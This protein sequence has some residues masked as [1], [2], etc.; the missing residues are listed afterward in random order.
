M[1][2]NI[3]IKMI[4]PLNCSGSHCSASNFCIFSGKSNAVVPGNT[5]STRL[6]RHP[7]WSIHILEVI[8][9]RVPLIFPLPRCNWIISYFSHAEHRVGENVGF[10]VGEPT[11][12]LFRT[13]SLSASNWLRFSITDQ[14]SSFTEFLSKLNCHNIHVQII[15]RVIVFSSVDLPDELWL[16]TL[17]D[18]NVSFQLWVFPGK[19]IC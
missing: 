7:I 3:E 8:V 5:F 11:D 1:L 10:G 6:S 18:C 17:V 19:L 2:L 14:F 9:L 4:W 16:E 15:H 13:I 12:E